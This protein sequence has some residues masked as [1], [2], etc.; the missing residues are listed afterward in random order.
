MV[1]NIIHKCVFI[2]ISIPAL[3]GQLT[4]IQIYNLVYTEPTRYI[5]VEITDIHATVTK[6]IVQ[7][8]SGSNGQLFVGFFL[9]HMQHWISSQCSWIHST[10]RIIE[11]CDLCMRLKLKLS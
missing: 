9:V 6:S 3:L 10:I 8:F 11:L 7:F 1:V 4:S 2:F 5:D